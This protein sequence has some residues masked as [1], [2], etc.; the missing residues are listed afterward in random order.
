MLYIDIPPRS[1]ARGFLNASQQRA[2]DGSLT[3]APRHRLKSGDAPSK[4]ETNIPQSRAKS[5][6]FSSQSSGDVC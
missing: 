2:T 3:V 6:G 1:K 4:T 5:T